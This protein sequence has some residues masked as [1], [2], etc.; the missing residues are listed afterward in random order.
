[1]AGS[2][3]RRDVWIRLSGAIGGVA[4]AG[5]GAA[6]LRVAKTIPAS[7]AVRRRDASGGGRVATL[8]SSP[9]FQFGGPGDAVLHEL[10]RIPALQCAARGSASVALAQPGWT[11]QRHRASADVR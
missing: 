2:G 8:G 5:D 7:D 9:R 3:C 1:M 11:S 10:F 4:G 6:V